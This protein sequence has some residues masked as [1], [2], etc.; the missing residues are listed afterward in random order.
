MLN[1]LPS[2]RHLQVLEAVARLQ[3]LTRASAEIHLTQPAV[4]QTIAKLE[5]NAG[6]RLF[7]RRITGTYLTK[8]GEMYLARTE[9]VFHGIEDVLRQIRPSSD[10][11]EI[12]RRVGKITRAQVRALIALSQ[13][14]S[15]AQAAATLGISQ[16]SL[17]R[18][19][20]DLEC[21]VG[22]TLY[23]RAS[24]GVMTTDAGQLLAC[25]LQLAINELDEICG[26]IRQEQQSTQ[27]CVRFGALVLDPAALLGPV[28]VQFTRAF[29]D[30]VVKVIHAPYE[31]LQHKLRSGTLDFI[32]GVLK[33]TAPDLA[34]DPLFVDPYIIVARKGHPLAGR[35]KI[36]VDDLLEYDWVVVNQGAP[37]HAAFTRLFD[38]AGRV[39]SSTIETH[40]LATIR[41]A[42]AQSDRL[43]LLTRSELLSEEAAGVFTALPY[44]G[45]DSAPVIGIT[46]RK[47]W[48]P[49][50]E[51]QAFLELLHERGRTLQ[52]QDPAPILPMPARKPS[53]TRGAAVAGDRRTAA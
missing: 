47:D 5:A 26:E 46:T 21:N 3:S 41:M 6:A 48:T 4:T 38:L 53:Q 7:E 2:L 9:R 42:M 50:A 19:A 51:K 29:P 43:T 36:E 32:V 11:A 10:R 28:M 33:S 49:S 22:A 35:A 40:S 12:S 17:H 39:P 27:R 37:R 23:H 45:L 52:K 18:A 24:T 34:D 1:A 8:A 20:R 15:Q 31:T 30:A 16:A 14:Q 13:S 44:P 25:R